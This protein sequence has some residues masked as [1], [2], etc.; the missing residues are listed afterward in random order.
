MESSW[1]VVTRAQLESGPGGTPASSRSG[2]S[3]GRASSPA[4]VGD[5][6]TAR[7]REEAM[8]Q[9][10]RSARLGREVCFVD[11]LQFR[12]KHRT[13]Q[14]ALCLGDADNDGDIEL[15]VGSLGGV[16]LLWKGSNPRPWKTCDSLG[17]VSMSPVGEC[18]SSRAD[19]MHRNR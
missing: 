9:V 18:L 1:E 19:I 17:S 12:W 3:A 6:Q 16:L 5:T 8:A 2:L 13:Y 7:G 14:K 4:F 10:E 11:R 15:A